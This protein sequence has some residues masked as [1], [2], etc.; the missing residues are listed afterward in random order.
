MQHHDARSADASHLPASPAGLSWRHG[1]TALLLVVCVPVF[2]VA[3]LV[4]SVLAAPVLLFIAA[5][6]ATEAAFGVPPP[7]RLS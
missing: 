1:A 2:L 5:G 6:Q 7:A 3:A 4:A